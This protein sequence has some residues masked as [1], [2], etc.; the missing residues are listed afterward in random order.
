LTMSSDAFDLP[1]KS[2]GYRRG[3]STSLTGS[4]VRAALEKLNNRKAPGICAITAEMLKSGGE[5][6]VE[7]LTHLFN[8]VWETERLPI[9]RNHR[10]I[11]LLSIPGKL[12]TR[13]LRSGH[14]Q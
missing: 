12:F 2:L 4:E 9:C 1:R 8:E 5:S 11:I 6:I 13:I 3:H 14:I 7:W 10:G